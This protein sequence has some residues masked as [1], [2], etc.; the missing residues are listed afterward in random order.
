MPIPTFIAGVTLPQDIDLAFI[1][2]GNGRFVFA[3]LKIGNGIPFVT[4]LAKIKNQRNSIFN[5]RAL[6]KVQ[7]YTA[8]HLNKIPSTQFQQLLAFLENIG[9][10]RHTEAL[11][12]IQANPANGGSWNFVI[13]EQIVTGGSVNFVYPDAPPP[14]N[15]FYVG[16]THSHPG[17]GHDPSNIDHSDEEEDTDGIHII[18][19]SRCQSSKYCSARLHYRGWDIPIRIE[20]IVEADPLVEFPRDWLGKVRVAPRQ[21]SPAYIQTVPAQDNP[22]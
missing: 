3:N 18:V 11:A 19:P 6:P 8:L 7:S 15:W 2:G 12:L 10:K 1:R 16:D 13:P 17:F 9:E 4:T 22:R 14:A 5:L 21:V 20:A